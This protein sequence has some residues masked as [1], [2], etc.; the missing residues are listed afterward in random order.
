MKKI[1]IALMSTISGLV[2]LFSYHTSTGGSTDPADA[3]GATGTSGAD[4]PSPSGTSGSTPSAQKSNGRQDPDASE[5]GKSTSG[6]QETNGSSSNGSNDSKGSG[7]LAAGTWTGQ[8]VS[9]RWGDVQVQIKVGDGRITAARALKYPNDNPKDV[10]IN[11]YALPILQQQT[12]E[13]QSAELD[14]VSG[15]TVTSEGYVRSLQSAIDQAG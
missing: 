5:A 10:Q 6:S 8:A 11:S 2:L 3:A 4:E 13:R 1:V 9:T 15:A 12:V 7:S 14:G